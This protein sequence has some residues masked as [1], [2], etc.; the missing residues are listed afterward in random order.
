MA[1]DPIN[2]ALLQLNSRIAELDR[3]IAENKRQIDN[4]ASPISHGR[5]NIVADAP[6]A[7]LQKKRTYGTGYLRPRGKNKWQLQYRINGEIKPRCETIRASS[8]FRAEQELMRR[9]ETATNA[10]CSLNLESGPFTV[11]MALDLHLA[12]LRR[13]GSKGRSVVESRINKHLI[14]RFGSMPVREF[15]ATT[16]ITYIESRLASGAKPATVNRETSALR[17]A[18]KYAAKHRWIAS[19]PDIENLSEKGNRRRGFFEYEQY[20][21]MMALLPEHQKMLLCFACHTGVRKGEL[22]SLQWPWMDWAVM[23]FR[24]P[25]EFCKNGEDHVIPVYGSMVQLLKAAYE[26]RSPECPYV[27]QHRGQRIKEI[28]KDW[29]AAREKLGVRFLFHDLRRTAA[30]FM[31]RAGIPRSVAKSIGGWK[32]DEMW[33]RY[34]IEAERDA[35]AA[36]STLKAYFE[37]F[38]REGGE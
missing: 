33:N 19:V 30:R 9:I 7:K 24:V 25:G 16:A 13:K 15:T 10:A 14:P 29:D 28:R 23:V 2:E 17:Q 21:Q 1:I 3:L 12:A 26:S 18:L 4:A 35:I 34:L 38:S 6:D 20:E 8:R 32:T 31:E 27:F 5:T 11:G 22:L 37:R 36:G